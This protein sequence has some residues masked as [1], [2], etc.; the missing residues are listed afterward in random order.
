MLPPPSSSLE[1]PFFP[2]PMM[3]MHSLTLGVPAQQCRGM[4]KEGSELLSP[5]RC[6]PQLRAGGDGC[7][8]GGRSRA[9]SSP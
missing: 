8:P 1:P 3:S 6:S 4:E 5:M 2:H 9:R 7:S